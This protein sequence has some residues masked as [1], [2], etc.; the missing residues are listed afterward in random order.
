MSQ[1]WGKIRETTMR[2]LM[3]KAYMRLSAFF[4]IGSIPILAISL[5]LSRNHGVDNEFA[6]RAEAIRVTSEFSW[7]LRR[8]EV[9]TFF[10]QRKQFTLRTDRLHPSGKRAFYLEPPG[11]WMDSKSEVVEWIALRGVD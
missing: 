5:N 1:V 10:V 6:L 8:N 9:H 4:I 3:G 7:D 2:K 11:V